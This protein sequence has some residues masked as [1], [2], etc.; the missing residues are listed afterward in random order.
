MLRHPAAQRM[1][2][3]EQGTFSSGGSLLQLP[4]LN[5]GLPMAASTQL[6]DFFHCGGSTGILKASHYECE[7]EAA[8]ETEF[9]GHCVRRNLEANLPPLSECGGY[10]VFAQMD[11]PWDG[12][13][14]CNLPQVSDL[15]NL[16]AAYPNATFVLPL[17]AAEKWVDSIT[18]WFP[19]GRLRGQFSRCNLPLCPEPCVDNNAKFAAFYE[20][21]AASVR[22]FVAKYPSH[23]LIEI[24]LEGDKK[25]VGSKLAAATGLPAKCWAPGKHQGPKWAEL[26]LDPSVSSPAAAAKKAAKAAAEAAAS[27]GN[28]LQDVPV[29]NGEVGD[30]DPLPKTAEGPVVCTDM[31]L[32]MGIPTRSAFSGLCCTWCKGDEG[33]VD[34]SGKIC[35]P[36]RALKTGEAQVMKLA[37]TEFIEHNMCCGPNDPDETC[38]DPDGSLTPADESDKVIRV[39]SVEVAT[40]QRVNM[41]IKPAS[42]YYP[43]WPQHSKRMQEEG[44]RADTLSS[45]RLVSNPNPNPYPYPNPDPNPSPNPNP[46]PNPNPN[47]GYLFNG[48]K[49]GATLG[50]LL[51]LN[52]CQERTQAIDLCFEDQDQNPVTMKR[53]R[54]QLLDIDMAPASGMKVRV[55]V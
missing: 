6:A 21:H 49:T 45:G 24:N 28:R 29:D 12:G 13:E 37:P 8:G 16:H 10:Q 30:G 53:A 34:S 43:S 51:Q 48:R 22:K 9:C 25:A 1:L 35:C 32:N 47:Q 7:N 17:M 23:K 33:D 2:Q 19:E 14:E 15:Y 52:M 18:A 42:E 39:E 36:T 4:V 5:L 46:Y 27:K 41:V 20:H 38:L 26:A 50:G 55:R 11:G 44:G 3:P 31:D 54:I 40:P